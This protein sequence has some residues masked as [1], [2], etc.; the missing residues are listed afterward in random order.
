MILYVAKKQWGDSVK[1]ISIKNGH[2]ISLLKR[3]MEWIISGAIGAIF[4]AL[5]IGQ[6]LWSVFFSILI[7]LCAIIYIVATNRFNS[8][9]DIV[10]IMKDELN[11]GNNIQVIRMG[12]PLSRSL[13]LGGR[14]TL[15]Y[16]L[17]GI[18]SEACDHTSQSYIRIDDK[19]IPILYIKAK[20]LIDDLG[21]TAYRI[22]YADIAQ[23][24]IR[25]GIE[26]ANQIKDYSLAIKGYRH[27]IGIFDTLSQYEDR[28]KAENS[29]R[30]ILEKKEYRDSFT[31]PNDYEHAVAEFDYAIAKTLI[32]DDPQK[33][34]GMAQKVQIVFSNEASTDMD[35]YV[36]TF[37]LIGDIY[38]SYARP[39]KLKLAKKTYLNGIKK[40][41]EYGRS[42]RLL[43]IAID[44]IKLLIKML[45]IGGVYNDASWED[46]D[47]EELSIYKKALEYAIR[48]EDRG[49]LS[50]LKYT[51]KKYL[52]KR[53]EI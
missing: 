47:T 5:F 10:K 24:H 8:K 14:N 39:E 11:A 50:E 27:L 42:E 48:I 22:G 29:G 35:R 18:I 34:L 7:L 37:D 25:E 33:A 16:K 30:D 44:Y 4:G 46:I 45:E 32:D 51:H 28:N 52:K 6:Y 19:K 31:N 36:K 12:Y 13:H 15:R 49:T 41:E 9:C 38:A 21:W 3:I 23:E 26:I 40:C 43:T 20:I 2:T 1:I 17:G 53:R